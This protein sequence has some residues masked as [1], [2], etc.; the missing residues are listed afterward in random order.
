MW[1]MTH[2]IISMYLFQF[3]KQVLDNWPT[4]DKERITSTIRKNMENTFAQSKAN[5]YSDFVDF[6]LSEHFYQEIED[7]ALEPV[8]QKVIHNLEAFINSDYHQKIEQRFRKWHHIYIEDPRRPNFEMMRV[9][10]S[11]IPWLENI[12]ILASP[13]F[14]IMFGENNYLI[15]DWK[16]GKE[17]LDVSGITDQLRIYALKILLKQKNKDLWNRQIEV[18]EVYLPSLNE[19]SGTIEQEDIEHIINKI[20]EDVEYQ[21]QFIVEQDVERNEP[22]GH[23]TFTRTSSEKKCAWC[24]FRSVCQKLKEIESSE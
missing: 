18:Y 13:D 19:K 21:K 17:R 9:D 14:W 8:I 4:P 24:T 6:W 7:D 12:S 16:S 2:R 3:K 20:L 10:V 15:L 22:L 23:T 11:H 5:D 1:E